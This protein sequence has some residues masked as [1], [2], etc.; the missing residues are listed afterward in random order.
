MEDIFQIIGYL[1]P[2][3]VV[4]LT[5]W[6]ILKEFFRQEERK[7]Q[8]KLLE[9]KQKLSF[10]LRLQ[11]YER[12]VL[13]LERISPGNLVMRINKPDLKVKQ[14][15]QLLI[16]TIRDEYDHNL[17]QQLYITHD[18][19]ELVK[20]AKEEMIRQI[21]ISAGKHDENASS[22]ELSKSLLEMSIDKLATRKA[23]NFIKTEARKLL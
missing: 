7:R 14:F 16:K 13:F 18:A 23:L 20:S 6:Y 9:E 12:I 11:A 8:L 19:W 2:A 4:F 3:I 17:S 1:L 21:N 5:A 10:P 22:A 15:Q